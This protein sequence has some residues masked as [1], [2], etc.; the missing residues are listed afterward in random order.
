MLESISKMSESLKS[1]IVAVNNYYLASLTIFLAVFIGFLHWTIFIK[2]NEITKLNLKYVHDMGVR[3]SISTDNLIF[4]NKSLS[5]AKE[6]RDS[7]YYLT[8]FKK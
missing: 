8:K 4:Y 2:D 7:L 3:D 5:K 1:A 6:D